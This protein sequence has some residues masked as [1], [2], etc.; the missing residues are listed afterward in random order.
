MS[1]SKARSIKEAC[2]NILIG[3]SINF[4]CN[5]I[6]FRGMGYALTIHDNL[7]IGIIF[8][9]VSLARQYIIRRWFAKND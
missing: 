2:I 3:Y 9:F 6:I 1:Q 7:I 5:M 8:T 4:V